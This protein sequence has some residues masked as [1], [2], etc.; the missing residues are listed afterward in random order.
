MIRG[1]L[2][3]IRLVSLTDISS[4]FNADIRSCV[5]MVSCNFNNGYLKYGICQVGIINS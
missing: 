4:T 1:Q 5:L 3:P 2:V